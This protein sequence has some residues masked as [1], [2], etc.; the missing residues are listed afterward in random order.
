M[1]GEG[2]TP[3]PGT[4]FFFKIENFPLGG[5]GGTPLVYSNSKKN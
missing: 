4:Q 1:G 3:L 5:G 2:G